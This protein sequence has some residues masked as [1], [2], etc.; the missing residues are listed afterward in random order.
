M[1]RTFGRW[2]LALAFVVAGAAVADDATAQGFTPRPRSGPGPGSQNPDKKGP[3]EA[4]PEGKD[5]AEADLPPLP[6]WPGAQKKKQLFLQLNG[7]F[8][9]RS[10]LFHNMN[11]GQTDLSFGN[12]TVRAPF[13]VPL[14]ERS[15]KLKCSAR[16]SKPVPGGGSR[17]LQADGCPDNTLSGANIRLRLEPTINVAE[18]VRIH[19]Q[20]DIFDNLVMGSTPDSIMGQSLSSHIAT[21][22]LTE[23]QEP[24]IVGRN[25]NT[26]SILVKRAWAEVDTPLGVLTAGRMPWQWGMGLLAN[27]GS[28]P[29]ANFGDTVDRIQFAVKWAGHRFGFAYDFAG[30][31]PDSFKI[32]LDPNLAGAQTFVGGGQ[33]IDL[34]QLDDIHQIVLFAGRFDRPE[35]IKDRLDRG[36]LVLNYGGLFVWRKQ[37]MDYLTAQAGQTGIASGLN[38]SEAQLG[39]TLREVSAYVLT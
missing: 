1:M 14:V 26:P 3:A 15:Q 27:D 17:D 13:W 24:P 19:T 35:V 2:T 22:L 20:I 37:D 38:A 4:A 18:K 29:D 9:F 7:Y 23:G 30:S 16:V 21:P 31:G 34:N 33:A 6:S 28:D 10:V 5:A 39:Q 36:D 11:L 32:D 25:A 12:T 8:R